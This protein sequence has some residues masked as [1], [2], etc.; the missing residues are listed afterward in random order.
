MS[1]A[2]WNDSFWA[3]FFWADGFWAG[4]TDIGET[5]TNATATEVKSQYII[6]DRTGFRMSVREGLV[7]D[8]HLSSVMTRNKSRDSFHP[9]EMVRST[10]DSGRGPQNPEADD[11][12]ISTAIS[13]DDL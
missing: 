5:I 11:V 7:Q 3:N 13:V 4:P 6:D 8:G 1:N 10:S 2:F 9:Q 12:F